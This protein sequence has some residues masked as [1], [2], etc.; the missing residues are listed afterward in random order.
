[1]KNSSAEDWIQ[2]AFAN[3]EKQLRNV[4]S[5]S[6]E[7]NKIP[8]SVNEDGTTHLVT[9][10]D[11]TSG[12]FPGSLWYIYEF[13]KNENIKKDAARWTLLLD[14]VKTIRTTHDIGFML[15]CS[16]GNAYRL[17]GNP[18]YKQVIID[19]SRT[20]IK[21]Y[22]PKV[23]CIKSWDRKPWS[24]KWQ[25]PV[26]IDNMMNLEMLF[27][28]TKQTGD[29]SFYHVA[30]NHAL[31]TLKN[32][33]RHDNSSYHVVDYDSLTGKILSK[34]THQGISDSSLWAR[35]QAW[36]LYGFTMC[37]R[38]TGN[39]LFLQQAEKIADYVL[40]HKNIPSDHIFYWDFHALDIP[41]APRDASAAALIAS[42]LIELSGY[43]PAKKENYL[44]IGETI[45][46]NL[47]SEQY[48]AKPGTNNYFILKHCTGNFPANS[49]IDKPLSYADYY[50]LEGL[51]RL[52]RKRI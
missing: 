26:I 40:N 22:N 2:K 7:K 51:I 31:T 35:G 44:K 28:A 8:R 52:S 39:K 5:G 29:S 48:T 19:G 50:Y 20:L 17:T 11:W 25:Y 37:Y 38:E 15:F 36:G 46:K 27:W 47:S 9:P 33:F 12:F 14:T 43:V 45:L 4:S 49:E 1:M 23:G 42:A 16:Y 32:H 6:A 10:A 13:T 21:R 18:E 3:A 41:K 30:N 34:G 24:A